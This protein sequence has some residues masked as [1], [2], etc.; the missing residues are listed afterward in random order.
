M[1]AVEARNVMK[2]IH[3]H[4]ILNDVSF[5]AN[6]GE[7]IGIIGQNG[8]GKSMLFKALSGLLLPDSG[9]IKVWGQAVGKNSFPS[10]FGCLIE[11]PGMLLQYSGMENLRLL[12]SIQKKC[13]AEDISSL[14]LRLGLSPDDRRP[15]RKYSLGMRQKL[16]IIQAVMENPKLVILDEPMNNL[17]AESIDIVRELISEMQAAY[18]ITTIISSHN[19]EDIEKLCSRVY[20]MTNGSLREV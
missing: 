15:V 9:T 6:E 18:G 4:Q 7:R 14:M 3:G 16:G 20:K 11:H 17:D 2:S 13:T 1:I 12:A 5:S 10:D 19:M 8:S